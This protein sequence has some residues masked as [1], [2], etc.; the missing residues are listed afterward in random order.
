MIWK[1]EPPEQSGYYWTRFGPED[2]EPSIVH[3]VLAEGME[4]TYLEVAMFGSA[5]FEPLAQ[6]ASAD[7]ALPQVQWIGPLKCP[8]DSVANNK[9]KAEVAIAVLGAANSHL[10]AIAPGAKKPRA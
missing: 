6:F 10:V 5:E 3:L 9:D 7:S 8:I 1:N 2:D 4:G